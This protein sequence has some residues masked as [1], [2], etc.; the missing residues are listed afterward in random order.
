MSEED[1]ISLF[2]DSTIDS[3]NNI[4]VIK[5]QYEY[6]HGSDLID[7]RII[8]INNLSNALDMI[9]FPPN[10]IFNKI[11]VDNDD[12]V[13]LIGCH[14]TDD[15]VVYPT[16]IG[17]SKCDDDAGSRHILNSKEIKDKLQL[18]SGYDISDVILGDDFAYILLSNEDIDD[19][20]KSLIISVS[21]KDGRNVIHNHL[22][23]NN[24]SSMILDDELNLIVAEVC[25]DTSHIYRLSQSLMTLDVITVN[26]WVINMI[27]HNSRIILF[28][29]ILDK[30]AVYIL[31]S[32][33]SCIEVISDIKSN[34]TRK[35][36]I[37]SKF[38]ID[39]V[40]SIN[41]VIYVSGTTNNSEE[42]SVNFIT[43]LKPIT[44]DLSTEVD[45]EIFNKPTRV[46]I[47]VIS[48]LINY[49]DKSLIVVGNDYKN[50]RNILINVTDD[51]YANIIIVK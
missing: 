8:T 39:K 20:V 49:Y 7:T 6:E 35:F 43:T 48:S 25:D 12:N 28:K 16:I 13:I 40:I 17:F 38:L 34:S 32:V 50:K 31:D 1:V 29:E 22:F 24:I 3:K 30:E 19:D 2:M 37:S 4:Y 33:T 45:N 27:N 26:D 21:S 10:F 47:D 44:D 36:P 42:E 15:K 11:V 41:N 46:E 5:E 23:R 14:I 18:Y 51:K 9:T